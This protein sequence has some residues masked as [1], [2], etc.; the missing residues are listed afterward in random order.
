M[1]ITELN[2]GCAL[3]VSFQYLD[4]LRRR[5]ALQEAEDRK[6]PSIVLEDAL[7]AGAVAERVSYPLNP[8][9]GTSNVT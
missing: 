4:E 8:I 9:I 2:P 7:D 6:W 3:G 1:K 5:K